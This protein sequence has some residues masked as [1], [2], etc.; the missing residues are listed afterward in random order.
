MLR[1]IGKQSNE[2]VESVLKKKRKAMVGR[3]WGGYGWWE[4]WVDGT[5]G[6]STTQSIGWVGVEEISA[7]LMQRNSCLLHVPQLYC[8]LSP[9]QLRQ[10]K[11]SSYVNISQFHYWV[12]YC[13]IPCSIC[14]ICYAFNALTL[15]IGRQEEHPACKNWV[16]RCW[17]GVRL[18]LLFWFRL[19]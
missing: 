17:C 1:S 19:T 4:W 18:L 14:R 13:N 7:R 6:G 10:T 5:D 3:I 11:Q 12:V 8:D 15:L 2:S 9:T 16:M